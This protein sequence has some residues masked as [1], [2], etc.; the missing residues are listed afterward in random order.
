MRNVNLT[1]VF[2]KIPEARIFRNFFMKE[3]GDPY[4][5]KKLIFKFCRI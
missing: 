3:S 1:L 4:T 2:E 5:K